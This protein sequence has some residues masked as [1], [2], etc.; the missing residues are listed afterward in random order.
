MRRVRSSFGALIFAG[1]VAIPFTSAASPQVAQ[2][3]FATEAPASPESF[4]GLLQRAQQLTAAERHQEALQTWQAAYAMR[5]RPGLWLEIGRSQQRLGLAAEAA[6]SFRRFLAADPNPPPALKLEAEQAIV[7]LEGLSGPGLFPGG[8]SGRPMARDELAAMLPYKVVKRR[9]HAGMRTGGITLFAIGYAAAFL[10]GIV[11][12]PLLV[13]DS[14]SEDKGLAA[15]SFCLLI[16]V[17]GP[18]LSGVVAPVVA[19][20]GGSGFSNSGSTLALIWTL[21][22]LFTGGGM[23]AAGVGMWVGSY[24]HPQNVVV[25]NAPEVSWRFTPYAN[26]DGAGFAA[27]GNF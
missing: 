17:A 13:G 3:P 6:A 16:P 23:Q 10:T 4:E 21:P 12:G 7:R 27:T 15:G 8:S 25:P 2:P 11:M 1:L 20:S 19:A 14:G 9:Y 24:R 26:R 22:W 5:Q 18:F